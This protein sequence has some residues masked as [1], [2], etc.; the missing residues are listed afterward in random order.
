MAYVRL[1]KFS[2]RA[3]LCLSVCFTNHFKV[4]FLSINLLENPINEAIPP[5]ISWLIQKLLLP[6]LHRSICH[7]VLSRDQDVC[8]KWSVNC[9]NQALHVGIWQ[10]GKTICLLQDR[11]DQTKSFSVVEIRTI[12]QGGEITVSVMDV[13]E[14]VLFLLYFF[15]LKRWSNFCISSN[16]SQNLY[17]YICYKAHIF[18]AFYVDL[19]YF[20]YLIVYFLFN[21]VKLFTE[22]SFFVVLKHNVSFYSVMWAQ[23]QYFWGKMVW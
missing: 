19:F 6:G 2:L 11:K 10:S 23:K 15:S 8:E 14:L 17:G 13:D 9:F 1:F 4:H 21:K 5:D 20:I 7:R 16:M 12:I 3:K 22:N 18:M